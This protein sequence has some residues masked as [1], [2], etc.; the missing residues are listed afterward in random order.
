[1][2]G[3]SPVLIEVEGGVCWIRLNRPDKL[4]SMTLEM[5][6]LIQKALDE[7]VKDDSVGCVVITGVGERAFCAG[8]DVTNFPELSLDGAKEFSE[9]GQKTVHKILSHPKPVIA[10]VN[11]YALGGGCELAAACDFRIAS[12]NARLG[13][14]ETRW[15]LIPGWGGTQRLARL[16]S[17]TKAAEMLM[18]AKII[19]AKEAFDIGLVNLVV[20][21]KKLMET[22]MQ[23]AERICELGPLAV[24]AAKQSSNRGLSLSLSDGLCLEEELFGILHKTDD[25]KEGPKAFKEKRK[26]RFKGV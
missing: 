7:V 2:S 10:A 16:V 18:M 1:M 26:P 24:R 15:G 5:H 20:P 25:A 8:A 17:P 23:W 21:R 22:A 13:V 11:G 4:N 9:R 14:P 19:D 12:E 6:D 3:E